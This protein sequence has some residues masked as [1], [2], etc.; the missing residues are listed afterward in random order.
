[1]LV[2]WF[3]GGVS[4]AVAT[5]LMIQD[6][7]EIIYIHIEDQHPDSIRFLNDCE[8]WFERKITVLQSP[9]KSV[10]AVIRSVKYVSGPRGA[11]CTKRLKRDVRKDWEQGR[12]NL[13]YLW[14]LDATE[15]DRAERLQEMNPEQKHIF[16]LI[17]K[18]ISKATAHEL[19][20]FSGIKRP[21][22][23]KLGYNNNNC[24]GCVKGSAGYWN[25]IRKDF[26]K[27]FESR[28]QL[29]R[30]IGATCLKDKQFLDELNPFAGRMSDKILDDCGLFCERL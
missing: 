19:L 28:A 8:V 13:V 17:E 5:K 7:D 4:S 20:K 24:I 25:Q 14:G 21:E 6:I 10:E 30:L 12:S 15:V 1:M 23:Y 22:M 27:V 18:S 2:S 11:A 16:P 9:Y 3:S 29:E 26:P